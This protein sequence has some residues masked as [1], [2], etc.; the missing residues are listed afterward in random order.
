[1]ECVHIKYLHYWSGLNILFETVSI[2][3]LRCNTK[4]VSDTRRLYQ[5]IFTGSYL[6][7]CCS[8]A[9]HGT[10][11]LEIVFTHFLAIFLLKWI[12]NWFIF[13]HWLIFKHLQSSHI[14]SQVEHM[15]NISIYVFS[16]ERITIYRKL[17]WWTGG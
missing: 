7:E 15:F 10:D 8:F 1:M 11:S 17:T 12:L 9:S 3:T 2:V 13:K 16:C 4:T 6:K 14:H 5:V